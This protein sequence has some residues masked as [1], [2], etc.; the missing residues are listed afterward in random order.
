VNSVPPCF[1]NSASRKGGFTLI[2]I[3]VVMVIVGLISAIL[4]TAFE[5]VLD[6]RVRLAAFL[7]GTDVPTLVA[8]WFRG[9]VEGLVPDVA[10]GADRFA[11]GP[12]GFT[13]LSLAPLDAAPGIPMRIAWVLQYDADSARTYLR[14]RTGDAAPV[15]VASWPGKLGDMAYCGPDLQ[16][17]NAWPPAADAAQLP[18][19]I[20]LEAVRGTE[21]WPIL[22]APRSAHNPLPKPL[23]PYQQ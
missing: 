12:Q 17:A 1:I 15:T 9:S 19:L 18:A 4:F 20:R 3:L 2:E 22:A 21:F 16:C 13:G 8:Q 6:I 14:Y 10:N 7:E 11:G 23:N 5:R